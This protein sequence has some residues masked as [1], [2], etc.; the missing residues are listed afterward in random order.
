MRITSCST[1][2]VGIGGFF[3]T[4]ASSTS[5]LVDSNVVNNI[6]VPGGCSGQAGS[7]PHGIYIAGY[8]YQVTNNLVSNAEGYGIHSYHDACESNISNN[9][10]VHNYAVESSS[11]LARTRAWVAAAMAETGTRR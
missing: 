1:L 5:G 8:H 2:H 10:V 6:G 9:T 3:L 7:G 4:S 11:A